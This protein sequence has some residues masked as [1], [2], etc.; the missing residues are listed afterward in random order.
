MGQQEREEK[1]RQ[2]MFNRSITLAGQAD[3]KHSKK[4]LFS[5]SALA[6]R[7]ENLPP[8]LRRRMGIPVAGCQSLSVSIH[9]LFRREP[10]VGFVFTSKTH[11]A[12]VL[13]IAI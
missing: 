10:A 4:A 7:S 12:S 1:Q 3:C 13:A 11:P 5:A 6:F 9:V 8:V 2:S